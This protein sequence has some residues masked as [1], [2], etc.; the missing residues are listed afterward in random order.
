LLALPSVNY[1]IVSFIVIGSCSLAQGLE[2]P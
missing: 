1:R 2:E